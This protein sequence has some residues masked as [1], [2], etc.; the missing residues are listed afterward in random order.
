MKD[1]VVLAIIAVFFALSVAYVRFCDRII[2]PDPDGLRDTDEAP[3]REEPPLT[4]AHTE[5]AFDAEAVR[6]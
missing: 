6:S 3:V 4:E 2:G 1:V 5:L